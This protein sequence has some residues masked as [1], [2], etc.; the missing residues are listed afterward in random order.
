MF[1]FPFFLILPFKV[2]LTEECE[3]AL[4]CVLRIVEEMGHQDGL[5]ATV[6]LDGEDSQM[7]LP[8]LSAVRKFPRIVAYIFAVCPAIL[9]FGF[10]MVIVSTLTAMPG[11]Q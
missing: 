9:L 11:F 4:R 1:L 10:D 7:T 3:T 8:L 6:A 5:E 2:F